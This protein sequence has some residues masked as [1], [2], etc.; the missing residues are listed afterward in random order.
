MAMNKQ[1]KGGF[2]IFLIILIV[3]F[4]IW[5]FV[6]GSQA[7]K[8][9]VTCDMGAGDSLCWKWHTNVI[10]QV[11]ELAKNTGN[12]IKDLFSGG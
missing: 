4:L 3:A 1:A 12:S 11:Q 10:G 6:G 7:Q 9:G 8:V 5:G 2:W